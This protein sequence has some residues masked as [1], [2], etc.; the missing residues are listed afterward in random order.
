MKF[1]HLKT[2]AAN[3]VRKKFKS[4]KA[5]K[6]EIDGAPLDLDYHIIDATHCVV[7]I[8]TNQVQAGMKRLNMPEASQQVDLTLTIRDDEAETLREWF[9]SLSN[10]I[11]NGD[12]T[13]NPPSHYL[14]NVRRYKRVTSSKESGFFLNE[15]N[16]KELEA[17]SKKP[18]SAPKNVLTDEWQMFVNKVGDQTESLEESGHH[19]YPVSLMSFRS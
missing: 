13:C 15:S 14:I 2:V 12:G 16:G 6:I 8:E 1:G 19:T 3:L 10:K 18:S 5:F 17:L 7:E 4:N 9:I 11:D